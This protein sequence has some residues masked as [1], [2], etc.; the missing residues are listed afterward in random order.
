MSG[1]SV[2]TSGVCG[3]G[4]L[5]KAGRAGGGD[6][7]LMNVGCSGGDVA[8]INSGCGG[9]DVFMNVGLA[10]VPLTLWYV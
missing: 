2:T 1:A 5:M 8:L 7:A 10:G 9:G 4:A 3:F 6:V